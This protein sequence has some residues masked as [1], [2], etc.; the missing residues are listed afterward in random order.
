MHMHRQLRNIVISKWEGS[1]VHICIV[2][3]F[4]TV[5]TVSKVYKNK[6]INEVLSF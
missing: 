4:R 3:P 5:Y 6:Q 1:A 2:L